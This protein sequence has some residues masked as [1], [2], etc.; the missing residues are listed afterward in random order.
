M[1]LWSLHPRYLD[2]KGLVALWREA[3]LAQAVLGGFTRGYR[4]HPQLLRFRAQAEPMAAIA[5][6]LRAIQ[7][8]AA[9]RGYRFNGTLIPDLPSPAPI[10]E[11]EGQLTLE[12][13]HLKT[14]LALRSPDRFAA[15]Q[16]LLL[17]EPHPQFTIQLGGPRNWEKAKHPEPAQNPP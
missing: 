2:P 10:V 12:W 4:S 5:S 15:Y 14:K 6:Y 3:L 1:R 7:G 16:D 9:L 13:A 11:T 17:P 8:E